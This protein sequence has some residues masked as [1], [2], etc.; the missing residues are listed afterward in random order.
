MNDVADF[1]DAPLEHTVSGRIGHHQRSEVVLVRLGFR[2]QIGDVDV[3]FLVAGDRDDFQA[4]HHGTGGIRAVSGRRDETNFAMPFTAAFVI[5]ADDEKPGV[6]ALRA[7]VGL[8]RNGGE[9]SDF[10]EPL[11]ELLEQKPVALGLA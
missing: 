9:T 6:F 11:F 10:R 8:K 3:P 2:A 1:L 4:S 5:F 7:S